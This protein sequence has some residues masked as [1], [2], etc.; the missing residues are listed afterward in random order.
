LENKKVFVITITHLKD[1]QDIVSLNSG[2]TTAA[3]TTKILPTVPDSL[4]KLVVDFIFQSI[5]G[6]EAS[7]SN[8]ILD[9]ASKVADF[10]TLLLV[11]TE[12]ANIVT[13]IF[14]FIIQE[15]P[16]IKLYGILY[17][18][19]SKKVLAI[20]QTRNIISDKLKQA[21]LVSAGKNLVQKILSD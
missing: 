4:K 8:E 18:V 3:G 12:D 15:K 20:A 10:D 16:G 17:D 11:L 1:N 14:G 21:S 6:K 5:E 19:K 2:I 13:T 7:I 9:T